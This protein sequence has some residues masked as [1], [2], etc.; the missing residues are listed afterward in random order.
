MDFVLEMC[1]SSVA[2]GLLFS[3]AQLANI[4]LMCLPA[5]SLRLTLGTVTN[6]AYVL[7]HPRSHEETTWDTG[8]C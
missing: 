2:D 7:T 1:A 5:N 6:G 8:L 3:L 4:P